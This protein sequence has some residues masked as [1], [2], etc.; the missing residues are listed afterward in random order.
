MRA[1][2]GETRPSK[3][4]PGFGSSESFR[5]TTTDRVYP[6][7]QIRP[8]NLEYPAPHDRDGVGVVVVSPTA[9]KRAELVDVM[10]LLRLTS[11]PLLGLITY[12]SS[13]FKPWLWL[14]SDNP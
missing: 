10:Q 5:E 8:L 2:H 6:E 3:N 7:V 13:R 12:G 9:L 11:F 14:R 1:G 4:K